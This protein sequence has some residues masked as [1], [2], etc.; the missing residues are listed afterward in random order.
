MAKKVAKGGAKGGAKRAGWK[1]AGEEV[2]TSHWYRSR[3]SSITLPG[4]LE[5]VVAPVEEAV[6]PDTGYW[7][8]AQQRV[9]RL[10]IMYVIHT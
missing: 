5:E 3:C 6:T 4:T 10:S 8:L 1:A 2:V 7:L 9:S